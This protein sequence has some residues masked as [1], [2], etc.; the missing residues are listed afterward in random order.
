VI[1]GL[2]CAI[3][4]ERLMAYLQLE[5]PIL[6]YL[7][8]FYI[9]TA[10]VW[11]TRQWPALRKKWLM[12]AS[13][14]AWIVLVFLIPMKRYGDVD[15]PKTLAAALPELTGAALAK[16]FSMDRQPY[17]EK[18]FAN[19]YDVGLWARAETAPTAL[20]LLRDGS[21]FR[22]YAQRSVTHA[23]KDLSAKAFSHGGAWL[24]AYTRRLHWLQEAFHDPVLLV[25][26]SR[27]VDADYVIVEKKTDVRLDWPVVYSNDAY[28]VY[29]V[30]P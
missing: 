16:D 19:E 2:A 23:E 5:Y 4:V 10:Y 12:A 27:E 11:L 26:R 21:N 25:E 18:G 30:V 3:Y 29:E 1:Y 28:I 15:R 20:F 9:V 6:T 13:T 22:Y 7:L 8:T 14:A 24:I 17:L